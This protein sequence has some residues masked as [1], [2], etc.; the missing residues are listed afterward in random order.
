MGLGGYC[1]MT[2]GSRN[3]GTRKTAVASQRLG[4]H[5]PATKNANATI[6]HK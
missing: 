5:F 6:E 4:K 3:S 1:D 2:A